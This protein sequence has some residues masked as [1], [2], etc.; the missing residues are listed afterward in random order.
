MFAA[1]ALNPLDWGAEGGGPF[2]IALII[3]VAL[4]VFVFC[5]FENR[6]EKRYRRATGRR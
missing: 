2:L 4:L 5:V 3:A 6:A 1:T